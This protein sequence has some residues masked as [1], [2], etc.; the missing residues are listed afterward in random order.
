MTSFDSLAALERGQI[1]ELD[2]ENFA[3]ILKNERVNTRVAISEN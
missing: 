1:K 2:D 3:F